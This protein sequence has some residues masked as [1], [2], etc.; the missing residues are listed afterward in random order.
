MMHYGSALSLEF[1]TLLLRP[2][3]DELMRLTL[4]NIMANYIA[5]CK[6]GMWKTIERHQCHYIIIE[7]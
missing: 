5:K 2:L 4:N 6:T 3:S 1:E 7:A